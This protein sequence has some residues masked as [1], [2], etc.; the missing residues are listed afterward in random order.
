[1]HG[2]GKSKKLY[3]RYISPLDL[4]ILKP[5]GLLNMTVCINWKEGDT[6]Q[7]RAFTD[8]YTFAAF[9]RANSELAESVQFK[10]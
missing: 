2:T 9:L 6:T 8:V 4:K 10:I 3:F 1:L 7:E 5:G